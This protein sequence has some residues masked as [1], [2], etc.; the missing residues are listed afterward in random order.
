[1]R[2]LLALITGV[3]LAGAAMAGDNGI[4]RKE[5]AASVTETVDAL[6]S[7]LEG[8]GLKIF[9]RVDHGAGAQS[10]GEDIGALL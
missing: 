8:A 10:I 6:V 9:A 5:A 4:V 7:T 2:M 3:F 1:M